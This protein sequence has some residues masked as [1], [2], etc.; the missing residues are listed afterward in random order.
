MDAIIITDKSLYF[1]CL[2]LQEQC[3]SGFP[4][5][6]AYKLV[7]FSLSSCEQSG[8]N[9]AHIL[10]EE[11]TSKCDHCD[12]VIEKYSDL[13][14][15]DECNDLSFRDR[16]GYK[17]DEI[18]SDDILFLDGHIA[19]IFDFTGLIHFHCA[20][21]NEISILEC[22]SPLKFPPFIAKKSIILKLLADLNCNSFE[23]LN[24]QIKALNPKVYRTV[25]VCL[26]RI[27]S[28]ENYFS[29]NLNTVLAQK[30]TLP[31]RSSFEVNLS[32]VQFFGNEEV[33]SNGLRAKGKALNSI[34]CNGSYVDG[35]TIENSVLSSCV[36]VHKYSTIKN[37]IIFSD[38]T[39]NEGCH[40]KN[41]IIDSSTVIP[42][43]TSIGYNKENDLINYPSIP[44]SS[45]EWISLVDKKLFDVKMCCLKGEKC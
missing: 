30:L 15:L 10:N 13:K 16:L 41:C 39:I 18:E 42:K 14:H 1:R 36:K 34:I 8:I 33:S 4:I 21:Y 32:P 22:S 29:F 9:K 5:A 28:I 35:A 37:C 23:Y 40:L 26:K 7:D 24:L 6:G 43:G 2:P 19:N 38:V 17:I 25:E 45:N 31:K 27:D 3:I 12:T 44:L 20:E 11:D